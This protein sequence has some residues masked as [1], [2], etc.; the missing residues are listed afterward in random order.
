MPCSHGC[1][2][3]CAALLKIRESRRARD[4]RSYAKNPAPKKAKALRH[5][6]NRPTKPP[7]VNL[8]GPLDPPTAP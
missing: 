6:H 1:P 7:G 3:C 5:Y 2:E 4:R 8:S